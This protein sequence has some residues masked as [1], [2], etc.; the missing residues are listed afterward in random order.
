MSLSLVDAF[1]RTVSLQAR[2]ITYHQIETDIKVEIEIAPS[3]YSRN[4]AGP[5]D[6]VIRGK[7]FIITEAALIEAGLNEPARGDKI[8]DSRMGTFTV[9]LS[10]EMIILGNVAGYRVRTS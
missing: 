4:L 5:E 9:S 1:N 7:E 10:R 6:T 2:T 3:N 8:I